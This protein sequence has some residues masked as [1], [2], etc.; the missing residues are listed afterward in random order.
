MNKKKLEQVSVYLECPICNFLNETV[1][2]E[3]Q[4]EAFMG[5]AHGGEVVWSFESETKEPMFCEQC[6]ATIWPK[7]YAVKEPKI[8][9]EK[10]KKPKKTRKKRLTKKKKSTIID[11][12]K[13]KNEDIEKN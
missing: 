2:L 8:L 1:H 3:P 4:K 10:P 6:T 12:S 13:D 5:K 11:A 9:K 7:E